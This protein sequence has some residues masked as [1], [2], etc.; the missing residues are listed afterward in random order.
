MEYRKDNDLLHEAVRHD[1]FE[2]H[3]EH[4]PMMERRPDYR[5]ADLL[6]LMVW[7]FAGGAVGWVLHASFS[8]CL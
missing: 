2:T 5:F 4:L 6:V 7:A 3:G 8:G 1:Y